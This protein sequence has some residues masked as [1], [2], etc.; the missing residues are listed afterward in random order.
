MVGTIDPN[1]INYYYDLAT[2]TNIG[3]LTT[4]FEAP[5]TCTGIDVAGTGHEAFFEQN[6]FINTARCNTT[7]FNDCIPSPTG[8][9]AL[10]EKWPESY[11]TYHSPGLICPKGWATA[12]S[13]ASATSSEQPIFATGRPDEE[14]YLDQ[15]P[16][17]EAET[18]V[19]CCPE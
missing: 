4:T 11:A 7:L 5:A 14:F 16:L 1:S 10:L 8:G 19:L 12:K 15:Y 17:E 6:Y 18:L 3:P 13:Y 2:P 9:V